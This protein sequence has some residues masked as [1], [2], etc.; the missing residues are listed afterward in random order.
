MKFNSQYVYQLTTDRQVLYE[1]T[2]E[3]K[4]ILL[5]EAISNL[6]GKSPQIPVGIDDASRLQET[7]GLKSL[8]E[9]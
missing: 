6:V 7:S 1:S 4:A 9:L 2:E 5:G 3:I 8:R